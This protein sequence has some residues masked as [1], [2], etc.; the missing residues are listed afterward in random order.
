ME[1]EKKKDSCLEFCQDKLGSI[2]IIEYECLEKENAKIFGLSFLL[3]YHA[4]ILESQ[5]T[6]QLSQLGTAIYP[7][8]SWQA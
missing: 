3:Y 4:G 2:Q 8:A 7:R 6:L 5:P 1:G